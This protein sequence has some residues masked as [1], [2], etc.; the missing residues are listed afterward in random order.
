MCLSIICS[1]SHR[2]SKIA[3]QRKEYSF[4]DLDI[5]SIC[6]FL[7]KYNLAVS[8]DL[9]SASCFFFPQ[10][11]GFWFKVAARWL[12]CIA[13]RDRDVTSFLLANCDKK[14]NVTCLTSSLYIRIPLKIPVRHVADTVSHVSSSKSWVT[15]HF[16]WKGGII[17]VNVWKNTRL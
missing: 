3:V 10:L 7:M 15:K 1:S 17:V 5:C 16:K 2:Y 6:L 4:Q 8:A 12:K 9:W 14:C 11:F 13:W